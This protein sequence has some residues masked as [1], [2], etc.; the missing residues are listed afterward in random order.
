MVRTTGYAPTL[1]VASSP[2]RPSVETELFTPTPSVLLST[3]VANGFSVFDIAS[4]PSLNGP[5]PSSGLLGVDKPAFPNATVIPPAG[6]SQAEAQKLLNDMAK[7]VTDSGDPAAIQTLVDLLT[8]TNKQKLTIDLNS[9]GLG[10]WN[11]TT[12]AVD[13]NSI[14]QSPNLTD[15]EKTL[16]LTSVFLHESVHAVYAPDG[17]GVPNEP[18]AYNVEFGFL[19]AALPPGKTQFKVKEFL[20]KFA[21]SNTAFRAVLAGYWE[22]DPANTGSGDTFAQF[23]WRKH[24]EYYRTKADRLNAGPWSWLVN[25]K[26]ISEAEGRA[27]AYRKLYVEAGGKVK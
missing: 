24:S 14:L 5:M 18:D 8:L 4:P 10:S 6:M 3:L 13:A 1:G 26:A 16:L 20:A 17:T 7:A 2:V 15:K 12:L 23:V 21:G 27:A 11:G 25:W 22:K 19:E 9:T